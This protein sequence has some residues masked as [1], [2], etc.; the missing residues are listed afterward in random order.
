[1]RDAPL[2]VPPLVELAG[3]QPLQAVNLGFQS[4]VPGNLPLPPQPVLQA[5]LVLNTGR[6]SGPC[7]AR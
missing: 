2:V 7:D 4:G 1:M 6:Y 3:H 5:Y